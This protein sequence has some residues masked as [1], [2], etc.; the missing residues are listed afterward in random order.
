MGSAEKDDE[1]SRP[2]AWH[3][4]TVYLSSHKGGKCKDGADF[5]PSSLLQ[6]RFSTLPLPHFWSPEGCTPRTLFCGRRRTEIQCAL[7][8]PALQQRIL[9][10][11]LTA[12]LARLE[13]RKL[14]MK[15]TLCKNNLN[16]LNCV[17]ITYANF[18]V[19]FIIGPE[20]KI[21]GITSLSPLIIHLV[22]VTSFHIFSLHY[23][24]LQRP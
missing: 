12:S 19:I 22:A 5:S 24:H 14:I 7:G 2:S 6:S 4:Q 21:E 1:S 10:D 8:A 11:R 17:P 9:C 18:T 23:S 16:I 20:I 15:K 3:R 13:I